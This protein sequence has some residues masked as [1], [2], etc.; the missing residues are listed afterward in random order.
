[1]TINGFRGR[2]RVE[3][4]GD[5]PYDRLGFRERLP[6][7]A[8]RRPLPDFDGLLDVVENEHRGIVYRSNYVIPGEFV[9]T[10][11]LG[12]FPVRSFGPLHSAF[13]GNRCKKHRDIKPQDSLLYFLPA[14][15]NLAMKQLTLLL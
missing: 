6:F 10:F 9:L 7:A 4:F 5:M 8:A 3:Q 14:R 1:M 13:L 12:A 2:K 15:K 11:L